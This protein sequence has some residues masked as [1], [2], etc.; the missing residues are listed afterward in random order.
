MNN[1]PFGGIQVIACGDFLQLSNGSMMDA[2][3][4]YMSDAFKHFIHVKLT[5]P[6]RH[7]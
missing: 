7:T 1:S 2:L 4:A 5:T 3:P 6:M